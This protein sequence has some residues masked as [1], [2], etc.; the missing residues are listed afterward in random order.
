MLTYTLFVSHQKK[1]NSPV[2][3]HATN[4]R[5]ITGIKQVH[6]GPINVLVELFGHGG[7]ESSV[8]L[9]GSDVGAAMQMCGNLLS[10]ADFHV[11]GR[12]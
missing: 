1:K 12:C 8:W 3:I 4:G 2:K 11:S 10:I 5:I 7:G 6:L 9:L